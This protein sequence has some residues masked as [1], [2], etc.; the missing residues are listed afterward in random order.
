VREQRAA[1]GERTGADPCCCGALGEHRPPTGRPRPSPGA[2][3]TPA[4]PSKPPSELLLAEGVAF[5]L[6][7]Q[8][9]TAK[10]V[11]TEK[12]EKRVGD[13]TAAVAQCVESERGK[14][15]A[16]VLRFRKIGGQ[17]RWTIYKRNGSQL[18]VVYSV[19][20]LF[21][22]ETDYSVSLQLQGKGN[23]YPPIMS[24]ERTVPITFPSEYSIELND[25]IWGTLIYSSKRG[26]VND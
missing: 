1:D 12:C 20:I 25:P 8:N 15:A 26:I 19:P 9:S 10:L 7:W 21:A 22:D 2:A 6:D 14:F 24:Q 23:G 11:A 16:D 18:Q 13:D 3:E 17:L 5:V 4:P